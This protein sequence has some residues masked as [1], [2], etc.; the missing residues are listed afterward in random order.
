MG[1][2]NV[3]NIPLPQEN[4]RFSDSSFTFDLPTLVEGMKHNDSWVQG[5]LNTVVLLKSPDKQ[6]LLTAMHEGTEIKF[7][8][9]NDSI[10]FEIVEG[11]ITLLTQQESVTLVKG[12]LLTYHTN[13]TLIL[14]T[15]EETVLL[16]TIL[17]VNLQQSV[18]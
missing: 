11:K 8:P 1:N 6:I 9:L 14:T 10:T 13:V 17:K 18:N 4:G 16:L 5:E 12:Q 3:A 15:K 2:I 7:F